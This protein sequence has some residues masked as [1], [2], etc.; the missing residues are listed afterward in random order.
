MTLLDRYLA[1][2]VLLYTLLVMCVLLTLSTL[3]TF[4]GQQDD[5]GV[6]AYRTGDAFVFTLLNLPQ[7]AFVLLPIG[8]LIG[9]IVGLGNLAH[10]SELVV[11][12]AAGV[13]V[14]RIGFAAGLAG[15]V[16]MAMMWVLGEYVAP[17]LEQYARQLKTFSKFAGYNLSGSRS[18]WVKDGPRFINV[19]Q[20]SADNMFGGVYVIAFDGKGAL[21]SVTRAETAR[22]AQGRSW[23]LETVAE[24]RLVD[25]RVEASRRPETVLQTDVNPGF[26]GLAVVNPGSLPTRGLYTYI[27]HLKRNGLDSG[28]YEIAFWSRISRT[29]AAL[30][31]CVLAVP[32]ALGPLRSA[33]AGARMVA[34]ILVGVAF[35]LLNRTLENSG[36]VYNLSPALVAWLPTLGLAGITAWAIGRAR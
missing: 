13:S 16:V 29:V 11:V 28:A 25:G 1:R 7:Q 18:A 31:V 26:L 30:I 4:L 12:R 24:T 9:A 34:G 14:W 17:P 2:T 33:G 6:G 23:T 15:C 5:I 35:F 32:F 19:Q 22:V 20:Q 3:F 21:E 10:E 36:E 8:A 27:A